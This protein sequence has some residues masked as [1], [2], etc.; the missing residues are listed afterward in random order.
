MSGSPKSSALI[1]ACLHAGAILLIV[2][3]TSVPSKIAVHVP[4][5]LFTPLVQ[6]PYRTIAPPQHEGGGGGG[7]HDLT[8]ARFGPPP[9]LA[10]HEFVP[11][12]THPPESESQI[13]I[14]PALLASNPPLNQAK[15]DI[16]L[17]G[18]PNGV[19]LGDSGGRGDGGGIGNGHHGGIGDNIGPGSG[20]R[21]G[22]GVGCC[23]PGGGGSGRITAPVLLW[24]TEPEYSEE[25]RRAKYQGTV[26]LRIEI[27]QQGKPRNAK[28]LQ[29]L[30]LGLDERAVD[31]VMKWKFKAA[32]QDGK[33]VVSVATIEVSFRLL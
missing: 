31:T 15:I 20:P 13:M 23:G 24:K 25:A 19:H 27:D 29:S 33:P 10:T 7:Q 30:G 11:P 4:D 26:V 17:L 1:S 5:R 12:T 2:S 9:R 18:S 8:P 16:S 32:M 21:D 14:E 22:E 28:V 6:P 3:V